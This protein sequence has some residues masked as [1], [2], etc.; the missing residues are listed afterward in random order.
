MDLEKWQEILATLG[1]HK[2][3]TGLTAF[4]VFWGI[5]MLVTLLGVGKGL[6]NGMMRANFSVAPNVIW[7]WNGGPAIFPYDGLAKGRRMQLRHE[8]VDYLRRNL[9]GLALI[10]GR[11]GLGTQLVTHG[12]K[13][14]SFD[15]RG[16][17]PEEQQVRD[18]EHLQGRGLNPLDI[19]EK[20]KV[21]VIGTRVRD[22]LFGPHSDPIGQSI[23]IFGIS[24]KVIGVF[25]PRGLNS[26]SEREAETIILPNTTLRYTFGQGDTLHSMMLL[27]AEGIDGVQMEAHAKALLLEKYRFH[28]KEPG[29]LGSYNTQ[30]DYDRVQGLFAGIAGFSWVVAVGTIIAGVV[31]VGN[32]MLIVV[33]ER[34]KEIGVRKAIGATPWQIVTMIVQ[35]ALVL[36]L[37]AGYAGL[38]AG[39]GVVELID[40]LVVKFA[41]RSTAF[42]N[43]EVSFVTAAAAICT[44]LAAGV[45]ASMLPASRAAAI[46]PVEALKDQ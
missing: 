25:Q 24:F 18:S 41:P 33:K 14:D 26:W 42:A 11:N 31:G 36:T 39:V 2:L 15:I 27:P 16:T 23:E 37:L 20:R 1:R 46:D 3:R 7:M 32:I 38:V 4:G 29:V 44:L 45:L 10:A 19:A 12:E 30:K 40:H 13:F 34:T 5:F 35:E 8:D 9:P 22:V 6:E 43:P 28:P 17:Y 21:A